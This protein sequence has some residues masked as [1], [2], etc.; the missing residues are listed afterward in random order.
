M[1][2]EGA[3]LPVIEERNCGCNS[4]CA[5]TL[6]VLTRYT[7]DG[8]LE[9]DNSAAERALRAVA[10]GAEKLPLRGIGLWMAQ[11]RAA[12]TYTLIGSA[13]SNGLDPNLPPH[14][15]GADR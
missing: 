14:R 1:D 2:G 12:A 10:L 15:A 11:N 4:I 8:S 7:E 6:A 9:V 3:S 13:K 5:L